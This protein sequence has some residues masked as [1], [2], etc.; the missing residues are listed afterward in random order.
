MKVKVQIN[1]D[2]DVSEYNAPGT[3]EG[4]LDLVRAMILGQA[5]WPDLSRPT[6]VTVRQPSGQALVQGTGYLSPDSPVLFGEELAA[7]SQ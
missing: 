5:D 3:A 2:L 6:T 4:A 1:F 7:R